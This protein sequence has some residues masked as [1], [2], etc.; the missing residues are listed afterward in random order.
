MN[1]QTALA[2]IMLINYNNPCVVHDWEF[3]GW[4]SPSWLGKILRNNPR[5]M[6]LPSSDHQLGFPYWFKSS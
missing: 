2:W 1:N 3:E 6:T 5:D 4:A